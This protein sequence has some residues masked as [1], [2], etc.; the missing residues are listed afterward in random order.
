MS[1]FSKPGDQS[2]IPFLVVMSGLVVLAW[3]S[4]WTWGRSPYGRYLD[5][6]YLGAMTISSAPVA[7]PLFVGG[8]TLMVVAMMLPTTLPLIALFRGIVRKRPDSLQLVVMLL[9][10]YIGVWAGFGLIVHLGD[11]GLHS[12]VRMSSW[13]TANGWAI[14]AGTL[15]LAGVY[16]FTSLKYRCLDEC[17]SPYSFVMG[18]WRGLS[19]RGE[20]LKLGI[21]HGLYCVGC[22]W[23]LMLL[24]F[25][26][27]HGSLAW[28]FLLG[29]VM[30]AEKNLSWGRKLA[31]PLGIVLITWGITLPVLTLTGI[32]PSTH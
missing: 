25:A 31:R 30:G 28:M 8:W 27:G 15:V 5:H 11:W 29:V 7:M 18:H 22:C 13:M 9:A 19:P 6:E 2:Q 23:S 26:V 16:Q 24:M 17:R 20:S 1:A 10:G 14:V 4:L 32:V 3:F 12:L 21:H